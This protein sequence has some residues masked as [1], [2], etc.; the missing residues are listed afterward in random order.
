MEL[1]NLIKPQEKG[2]KMRSVLRSV[3]KRKKFR[4]LG[5]VDVT[6]REEDEALAAL[7]EL[8]V[9]LEDRNQSAA[10]SLW[11]VSKRH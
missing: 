5:K 3:E 1:A 6:N 2:A 8:H 7:D 10:G 4:R 9:E 11:R